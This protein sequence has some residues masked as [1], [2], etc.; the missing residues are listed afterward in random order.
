M[1]CVYVTEQGAKVSVGKGKLII[2]YKNNLICYIPIETVESI[3]LFGNIQITLNAQKELL[4]RGISTSL[5]STRGHYYGRLINTSSINAERLKRQVYLSDNLEQR[6]QFAKKTI[7]AK[8][9]NQL[10]V[11]RRY[12]DKRGT[13]T[14]AEKLNQLQLAEKKLVS[15]KNL[16]EALGIE[17]SAARNY[18]GILS[19]VII[20]DFTFNGR[21]RRPPKDPFNAMISLG[22]T[23]IIYEIYAELENQNIN[24]YIGFT[25]TLQPRHPAL[26][27]DL[28]EE[29]RAVLVDATVMSMIQGHEISIDEFTRD[30]E[31]GGVIMSSS[32]V[33]KFIS[34]LEKKMA[35]D[36]NYLSYLDQ[37]VS[38]RRGIWWQVKTLANCI[39]YEKL[40][41]YMPLRI[42]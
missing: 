1:S 8:I 41:D 16:E 31:T 29:W 30:E 22:Y 37:S 28:L 10:V 25:H 38:F 6:L 17:G 42:R 12:A 40:G 34:K 13:A 5:L 27:S 18:F 19:E 26:V 32:G 21:N 23:I 14:I 2:E 33:R 4:E 3:M 9:H 15:A 35:S 24:P 39:D 36:M 7:A 11:A 20:K